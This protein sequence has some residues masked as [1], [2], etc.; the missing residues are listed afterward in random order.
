MKIDK[1]YSTVLRTGIRIDK[2]LYRTQQNAA[3]YVV[4]TIVMSGIILI[5]IIII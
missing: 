1:D 4:G 5:L 2:N 3:W